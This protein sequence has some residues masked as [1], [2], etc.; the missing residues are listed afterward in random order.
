M[1]IFDLYY[2]SIVAMQFH[3]GYRRDGNFL[4]LEDCAQI[5]LDMLAIRNRLEKQSCLSSQPD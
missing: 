1:E 3:P 5:A 4:T 2:A